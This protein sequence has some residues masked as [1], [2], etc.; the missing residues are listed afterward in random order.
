MVHYIYILYFNNGKFQIGET[1]DW[2]KTL[3]FYRDF[4][5][6]IQKAGGILN[7]K[8]WKIDPKI[9]KSFINYLKQNYDQIDYRYFY[10]FRF[11]MFDLIKKYTSNH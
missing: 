5:H 6:T 7:Y 8:N 3:K 11:A 10:R 4:D 1:D 2:E 9:S